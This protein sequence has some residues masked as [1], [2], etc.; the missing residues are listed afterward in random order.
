MLDG[1]LGDPGPHSDLY[2]LGHT[3]LE[4]L[5][6]SDYPLLFISAGGNAADVQANW[7][8]WHAHPGRELD[9]LV[10]RCLTFRLHCAICWHAWVRKDPAHRGSRL[11]TEARQILMSPGL[12]SQRPLPGLRQTLMPQEEDA[13]EAVQPP[14]SQGRQTVGSP[15]RPGT[16]SHP[17]VE[18]RRTESEKKVSR[19]SNRCSGS[20]INLRDSSG[21]T[22]A[23]L[24]ADA[25]LTSQKNGQWWVYDLHS[26]HG[27]WHNGTSV[28]AARLKQGDELR[29]AEVRCRVAFSAPRRSSDR[30]GPFRLQEPIH[31]GRSGIFY[32]CLWPRNPS[33]PV[34]AVA[35]SR[36]SSNSM[37]P[38]W[39]V[40]S[41]NTAGRRLPS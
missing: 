38:K 10:K 29:F 16:H 31:Q 19:Q 36:R 33:F 26:T 12:V 17:Q 32:R 22:Q 1:A 37:L 6:G 7:L 39:A 2:C 40:S 41:R 4:L 20:G 34:V 23:S 8:G 30:M 28:R 15:F 27:T 3:A 25:F 18:T 11:A 14:P 21:L 5:L 9:N 35:F 13:A 24:D